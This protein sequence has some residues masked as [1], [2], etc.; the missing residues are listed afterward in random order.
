M[1][2]PGPSIKPI[3]PSIRPISNPPA[4]HPV[5]QPIQQ[6]T[7]IPVQREESQP[8]PSPAQPTPQPVQ[9]VQIQPVQI[10]EPEKPQEVPQVEAPKEEP[11]PVEE[12]KPETSAKEEEKPKSIYDENGKVVLEEKQSE[13]AGRGVDDVAMEL[14]KKAPEA[15]WNKPRILEDMVEEDDALKRLRILKQSGMFSQLN[16]AADKHLDELAQFGKSKKPELDE[17]GQPVTNDYY[18][19]Q[20][21]DYYGQD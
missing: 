14:M 13:Y 15:S 2:H 16:D 4:I 7:V 1:I 8:T 5:Q 17:W 10:A 20:H 6:P 21:N 11:K 3:V 12:V 9:P 19:Q 18:G